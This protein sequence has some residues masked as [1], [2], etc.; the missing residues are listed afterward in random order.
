MLHEHQGNC[1]SEGRYDE[2]EA[3]RER[4]EATKKVSMDKQLEGMML[5]QQQDRVELEEEEAKFLSELH[6]EQQQ[7]LQE[8][9][10][11]NEEAT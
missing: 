1:I 6:Q 3:T 2:A 10:D 5:K 11:S 7:T 9:R 4:I 8:K